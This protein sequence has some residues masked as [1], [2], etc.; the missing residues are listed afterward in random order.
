M[1]ALHL[2]V[3]EKNFEDWLLSSYVLNCEPPGGGVSF[4]PRGTTWTNLVEVHKEM[5]CTKYQSSRPSSF[6]EEE[7]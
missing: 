4:D 7:S 1:K 2:S 3:S 6:K 5:L